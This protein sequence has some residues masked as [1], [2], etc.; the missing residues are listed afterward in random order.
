MDQVRILIVNDWEEGVQ[1][2]SDILNSDYEISKVKKENL[3][4][5]LSNSLFDSL[6][7]TSKEENLIE[8]QPLI[9][10]VKREYE[11]LPIIIV[12]DKGNWKSAFSLVKAGVD[13][14][15]PLPFDENLLKEKIAGHIRLYHMTQKVFFLEDSETIVSP[16]E[17]MVGVS[18]TMQENF[19]MISAVAQ[20]NATVL[21]SGESGTGKELVAKAIHR[22]S[23]RA[24]HRFVDLNCGAI[25]RDLLENELFGHE[26]GAFTGAHKRYQGSFEVS[27]GGTLFLDEISEMDPLLQ[28]KLLRVIQERNF[29]RIGGNERI[30]VDV[31]IIAATNRN[32]KEHIE[33]G[34]FR[35]DL[36]YRLNVVNIVVPSLRERRED[37]PL[38]SKHFLEYYAA[39]NDRIFLDIAS[40]A[41]EAL[42]NYDWPG[43]VRELENTMERIV[44]L[45]ND[46]QV[47]LKYLPENIKGVS[48]KISLNEISQAQPVTGSDEI[49]TMEEVEKRTIEK[50]LLKF[51]G[52]IAV[53]S[54][55]LKLGQATLYRKIKKYNIQEVGRDE[56]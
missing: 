12:T 17:G 53:A 7:I 21:I 45:H 22:R 9:L 30:D 54:K 32:L 41:L 51:Q 16:Y 6:I 8:F 4:A 31:R 39:K 49:L 48:R 13:E 25:P 50:A 26:K 20:S 24:N 38:L 56:S 44:V 47:K 40:D 1:S 46:S 34:N 33:K 42:I 37:I 29:M 43:N 11:A 14:Y 10:E 52:N 35:E 2:I 15:F 19:R 5:S 23:K 18:E 36:Y 28:V 27:D 3:L 55:K